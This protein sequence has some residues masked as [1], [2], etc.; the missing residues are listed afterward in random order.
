M[1]TRSRH[2]ALA[3]CLPRGILIL[4]AILAPV[5]DRGLA[6]RAGADPGARQA[7]EASAPERLT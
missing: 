3:A 2:R 6:G 4:I 1:S 5:I 7:Q